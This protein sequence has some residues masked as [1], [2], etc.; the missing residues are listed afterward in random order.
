[1]VSYRNYLFV[2]NKIGFNAIKNYK[3][4]EIVYVTPSIYHYYLTFTNNITYLAWSFKIEPSVWLWYAR[5]GKHAKKY[6]KS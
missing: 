2:Q 1:M 6:T 4:V 5:K 3:K